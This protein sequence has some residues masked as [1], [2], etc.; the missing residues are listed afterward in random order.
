MT[1]P[2]KWKVTG[3]LPLRLVTAASLLTLVA[4]ASTPPHPTAALQAAEQAITSAE[5]ARVADF[6]SPELTEARTKL[7]AARAA[8]QQ[9]QMVVAQRLAEQARADAELAFAKAGAIKAMKVNEEMQQSN[10]SL[11]QEMMRN[12]GDA[13]Q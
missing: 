12:T 9:Q 3:G 1:H 13:Q 11:N 2:T 4:C 5:Q 8:D 7:T 10:D 6:A